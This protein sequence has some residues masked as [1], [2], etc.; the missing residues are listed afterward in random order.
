LSHCQIIQEDQDN[1]TTV[2]EGAI[3]ITN[4]QEVEFHRIHAHQLRIHA[5]VDLHFRAN[6]IVHSGVIL[7]ESRRITFYVHP[8]SKVQWEVKDFGWFQRDRPSP[9]YTIVLVNYNAEKL[10]PPKEMSP[11]EKYLSAEPA[12]TEASV[13]AT[14]I[15]SNDQDDEL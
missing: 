10:I 14:Q 11:V 15:H 9:N 6:S 5:S 12:F 13:A 8:N 3:H 4:C 2:V 7:E 1:V